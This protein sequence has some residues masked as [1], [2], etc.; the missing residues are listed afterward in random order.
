[1]LVELLALLPI[2]L[3]GCWEILYSHQYVCKMNYSSMIYHIS[4]M[5]VTAEVMT[6]PHGMNAFS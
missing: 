1:M 4:F 3:R 5:Y 2:L 6:Y